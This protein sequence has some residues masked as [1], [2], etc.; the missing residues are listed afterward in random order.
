[1]GNN[2]MWIF[3]WISMDLAF[4]NQLRTIGD[5]HCGFEH[6]F[7][8]LDTPRR[9][10]Y[11]HSDIQLKI[12]TFCRVSKTKQDRKLFPGCDRW[13]LLSIYLHH[14][15]V[16]NVSIFLGLK[17]ANVLRLK[18]ASA[19]NL[20]VSSSSKQR[21]DLDFLNPMDQASLSQNLPM[22]MARSSAFPKALSGLALRS[23]SPRAPCHWGEEGWWGAGGNCG[24]P[25]AWLILAQWLRFFLLFWTKNGWPFG[26]HVDFFRPCRPWA[27][28]FLEDHNM[29][30]EGF[31]QKYGYLQRGQ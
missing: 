14:F 7:L 4:L 20:L 8:C 1:M 21:D 27:L 25:D 11:G 30:F 24:F 19:T 22:N 5:T 9:E 26:W 2:L 23:Q 31:G 16:S 12:S 17:I 13:C 6:G 28:D 3:S 18:Q 10:I 15:Q 29:A